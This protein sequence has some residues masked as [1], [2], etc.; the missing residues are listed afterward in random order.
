MEVGR[1]QKNEEGCGGWRAVDGVRNQEETNF[2]RFGGA[3]RKLECVSLKALTQKQSELCARNWKG[4]EKLRN[5]ELL[6]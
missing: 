4:E 6:R 1:R 5:L 2:R 3:N